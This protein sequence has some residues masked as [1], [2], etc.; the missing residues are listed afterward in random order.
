MIRRVY[1]HVV[2]C[3][4]LFLPFFFSLPAT[5]TGEQ[6]P[7]RQGETGV[8]HQEDAAQVP[9]QVHGGHL[10]LQGADRGKEREDRLPGGVYYTSADS[11][12]LILNI[13]HT[14]TGFRCVHGVTF[15]VADTFT[16]AVSLPQER[17]DGLP[18]SVCT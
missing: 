8:V 13:H 1:V 7:D 17:E 18:G 5:A 10:A 9:G 6:P 4:N 14:L 16:V 2:F 15:S 12:A 3:L 11:I